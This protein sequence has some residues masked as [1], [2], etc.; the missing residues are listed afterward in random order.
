MTCVSSPPFSGRPLCSRPVSVFCVS[1]P[2]F[3]LLFGFSVDHS[4]LVPSVAYLHC[5]FAW[6]H[7]L[8]PFPPVLLYPILS[9]PFVSHSLNFVSQWRVAVVHGCALLCDTSIAVLYLLRSPTKRRDLPSLASR[10][11][12]SQRRSLPHEPYS[13]QPLAK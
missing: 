4:P 9:V 7:V 2:S 11:W 13:H 1:S 12:L 10:R 5:V 8:C 6:R 3:V